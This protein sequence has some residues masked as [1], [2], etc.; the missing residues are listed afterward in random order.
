MSE[1]PV[2]I[3]QAEWLFDGTAFLHDVSLVI[4]D[5]LIRDITAT[6]PQ[7]Q[8]YTLPKGSLLTA[9]FIDAQVNGGGGML[10]NDDIS[11]DAVAQIVSAHRRF[12]TTSMLPT[13]ISDERDRMRH[14]I[15]VIRSAM[16]AKVPGILGIHLEGPFLNVAR[17]GVHLASQIV[18][19]GEE[20]VDLLSSLGSE[21]ITL[22]TLAPEC[23]EPEIIAEL[24]ARGVIVAAGHTDADA[25]E[26]TQAADF[27]LTG[28]THLYNAMS[29]LNSR[30]PGVVGAAL[31]DDRLFAGIIADGHHV[32]DVALKVAVRAK[33]ASRLMLVTDAMPTVGTDLDQFV[34]FGR[35][36]F[37][38]G[39][40]LTTEDG[41][42][43]GASI[44]MSA[45]VRHMV[46][47][48]DVSLEQALTMASATPAEFLK[49]DHRLGRLLPG[50]RADIVALDRTSL[51]VLDTWV[52]GSG[53][54]LG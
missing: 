27:G 21:G 48:I 19:I 47:Q 34:L 37:V 39:G 5:G 22:V 2:T 52:A 54:Q 9:G 14:A 15:D 49:I 8:T 17:K 29:Q 20:D 6:P 24:V 12:G 28:I 1:A 16:H 10:F 40:R 11:I 44:D 41:T 7:G 45:C 35:D 18:P 53:S 4:S 46:H 26:I 31:V 51:Y 3:L 38:R 42:I 50:L 36:I 25:D 30:A 32:S 13:F 33:G 43:A 23:M